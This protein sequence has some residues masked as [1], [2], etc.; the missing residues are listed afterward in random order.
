MGTIRPFREP[1]IALRAMLGSRKGRIVPMGEPRHMKRSIVLLLSV[2]LAACTGSGYAGSA[3][4]AVSPSGYPSYSSPSPQPVATAP[5]TYTAPARPVA[6]APAPASA[7]A[8]KGSLPASGAFA[9][10]PS[11]TQAQQDARSSGRLVCVEVGRNAC[12]NCM[13]L[14]H[15]VIPDPTVAG[16]LGA[17]S[18]GYFCDVDTNRG[19]PA[20][21]V[22]SSNLPNA[23]ILP[24]VAWLT[25]DL[26]WVHGFS[27]HTD[28]ARFRGEIARAKSLYV[29]SIEKDSPTARREMADV[30]SA[31]LPASEIEDVAA[32]I[33]ADAATPPAA[34][35]APGASPAPAP[36]ATPAAP[37]IPEVAQPAPI[38]APP[39]PTHPAPAP[40]TGAAPATA[41]APAP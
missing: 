16:E 7:P 22:I 40:T 10:D 41:P 34:Q 2:P 12:G 24:L 26:R 32:L 5:R 27:G 35:P 6:T 4:Y 31:S 9:W 19:S 3:H 11:L 33:G 14:L 38:E 29:A 13:K 28:V 1:S 36:S 20:F 18:V 15:E 23:V 37:P 17:V 39:A 8:P 30:P 25:P 21:Q